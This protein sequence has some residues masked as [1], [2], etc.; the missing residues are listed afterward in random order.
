MPAD[1]S[2]GGDGAVAAGGAGGTDRPRRIIKGRRKKNLAP[3]ALPLTT[4]AALQR[5]DEDNTTEG[6]WSTC[7]DSD[8]G[9]DV[10]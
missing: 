7:S 9:V 10:A 2:G 5:Y 6:D 3:P 8:Q 4:I 1:G